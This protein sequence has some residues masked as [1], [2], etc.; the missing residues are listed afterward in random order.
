MMT[1]EWI[2]GGI[3]FDDRLNV[4]NALGSGRTAAIISDSNTN[5]NAEIVS[6]VDVSAFG[7]EIVGFVPRNVVLYT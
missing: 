4:V 5:G 6:V 7:L 3:R 1:E 2:D